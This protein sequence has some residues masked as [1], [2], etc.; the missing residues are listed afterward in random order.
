MFTNKL[1]ESVGQ[2]SNKK[3]KVYIF[4]ENYLLYT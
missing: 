4:K 2:N 1:D 3:L